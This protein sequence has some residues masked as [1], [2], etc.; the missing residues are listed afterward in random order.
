MIN[1]E[2][3]WAGQHPIL[4]ELSKV[5]KAIHC[6]QWFDHEG[7]DMFYRRELENNYDATEP[8]SILSLAHV[9]RRRT[10]LPACLMGHSRPGSGISRREELLFH[11]WTLSDPARCNEGYSTETDDYG[12]GRRDEFDQDD[13]IYPIP[14]SLFWTDGEEE[15][16][17]ADYVPDWT[18]V[19][20]TKDPHEERL[21][22]S[23]R[24]IGS[25]SIKLPEEILA[26]HKELD[27]GFSLRFVSF[28]AAETTGDPG[29]Y[30]LWAWLR[31]SKRG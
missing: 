28:C 24:R 26:A 4:D 7:Y 11:T 12:K 15:Q 30:D 19:V 10:L 31:N 27:L 18:E 21:R 25:K 5:Y 22:D 16:S 29:R 1:K 14:E 23:M 9:L 20:P 17:P 2:N 3:M 6:A 8:F 13:Y